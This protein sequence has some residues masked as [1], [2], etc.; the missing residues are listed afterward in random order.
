M[1]A[2]VHEEYGPRRFKIDPIVKAHRS[3][4]TGRKK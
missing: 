3:A 4:D 2:A 1:K